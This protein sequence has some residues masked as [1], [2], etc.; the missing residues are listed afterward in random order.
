ISFQ[1]GLETIISSL[2]TRTLFHLCGNVLNQ[3]GRE[4]EAARKIKLLRAESELAGVGW[5][6]LTA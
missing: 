5:E 1:Q 4:D 2:L 6:Y 3:P